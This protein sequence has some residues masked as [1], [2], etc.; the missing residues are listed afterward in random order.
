MHEEWLCALVERLARETEK[1]VQLRVLS[2]RGG[3]GRAVTEFE[4]Y[5]RGIIKGLGGQLPNLLIAAIDANCAQFVAA[6]NSVKK[7]TQPLFADRTVQATP[8]PHI[9][10]WFLAD[11]ET[12]HSV[13]GV[14]PVVKQHKCERGYYKNVLAR[15]VADAG[16][17]APLG[18][19]EFAREI[20]EAMDYYRAGKADNSLKHFLDE[21]T[22]R[23]KSL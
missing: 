21:I 2:A 6:Q 5:Q 13:V 18:G 23:F 7:A 20:V 15:A 22:A 4:I 17:P 8:D 11:L 10:R 16:H 19:I 12:F 1:D 14:T 9:E 3:H